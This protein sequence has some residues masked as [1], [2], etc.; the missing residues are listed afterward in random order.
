MAG[1]L[2]MLQPP[3]SSAASGRVAAVV[4]SALGGGRSRSRRQRSAGSHAPATMAPAAPAPP[5]EKGGR[6]EQAPGGTASTSRLFADMRACIIVG[7]GLCGL[8]PAASFQGC[9]GFAARGQLNG[10]PLLHRRCGST[11]GVLEHWAARFGRALALLQELVVLFVVGFLLTSLLKRDL[12]EPS[13]NL[14]ESSP[15]LFETS[16]MIVK[17]SPGF[18]GSSLNLVNLG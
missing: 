17:S 3:R 10:S 2:G 11:L 15:N 9:W 5:E 13:M 18:V 4:V 14:A 6:Q 8:C 12:V 1:R 7:L 16:L